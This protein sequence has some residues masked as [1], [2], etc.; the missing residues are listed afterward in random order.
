GI[1]GRTVTGVQTCAL[2]ISAE[3][4]GMPVQEVGARRVG[5]PFADR[6][7][8]AHVLP[9]VVIEIPAAQRG[10]EIAPRACGAIEVQVRLQGGKQ[11]S[12]ERR[13]GKGWRW[14]G[15]RG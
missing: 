9:L 3:L 10:V 14:R 4:A 15:G 11:R 5:V 12:E 7:A 13:V 2:P 8:P 1:R 6:D